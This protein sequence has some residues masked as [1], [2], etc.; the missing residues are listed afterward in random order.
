ML[1]PQQHNSSEDDDED[2]DW[3]SEP[4]LEVARV[5]EAAR[6]SRRVPSIHNK[7]TT[8]TTNNNH[9][10]HTAIAT[11]FA[12]NKSNGSEGGGTSPYYCQEIGPQLDLGYQWPQQPVYET[13]GFV[14]V[15]AGNI[16]MRQRQV[17]K[18]L[19][20]RRQKVINLIDFRIKTNI[21]IH[22][23]A[24]QEFSFINDSE[25]KSYIQC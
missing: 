5:Q 1:N 25:S 3:D 2:S 19:L 4:E 9:Q 13:K 10:Q 24:I 22:T 12:T 11:H 20:T 15:N 21:N 17:D 23:I 8:A 6:L 7:P 18:I 14:K 16:A